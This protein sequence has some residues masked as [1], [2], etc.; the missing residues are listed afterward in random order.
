MDQFSKNN[1]LT[2]KPKGSA[3]GSKKSNR[4]ENY[5]DDELIEIEID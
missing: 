1:L 3:E 5:K 2:R 4:E